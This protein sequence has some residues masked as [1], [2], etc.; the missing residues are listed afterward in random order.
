MCPVPK[1]PRPKK[2]QSSGCY[3]HGCASRVC[4][5]R[6]AAGNVPGA[7]CVVYR[8]VVKRKQRRCATDLWM[9]M[10]CPRQ[11]VAGCFENS[12][13]WKW[14][15]MQRMCDSHYAG[16][17]HHLPRAS[18]GGLPSKTLPARKSAMSCERA[19]TSWW[20]RL[21]QR[22]SRSSPPPT[23]CAFCNR[24]RSWHNAAISR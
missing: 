9:N 18:Q 17:L 4:F 2:A 1:T 22:P 8:L 13:A 24:N 10:A 19:P 15:N 3:T 23:R 12:G 6:R 21:T 7:R 11:W 5:V 14:C 20:T 16:V